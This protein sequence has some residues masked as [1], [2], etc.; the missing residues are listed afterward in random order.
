MGDFGCVGCHSPRLEGSGRWVT[1]GGVPDL[2][3]APPDV[4]RDWYAILLGGSHR[5]QGMLSFAKPITF[6]QT[7]AMTPAQAEDIHAY[8]IDRAWAAYDSQHGAAR[9]P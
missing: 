4:H 8:V 1:G 5:E 2:R 3:Y 6:P 7:P 9:A